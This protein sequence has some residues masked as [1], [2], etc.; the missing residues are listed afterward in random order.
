MK[1]INLCLDVL[2]K[3]TLNN[4][5]AFKIEA[6]LADLKICDLTDLS[7]IITPY[8]VPVFV[9]TKSV[10]PAQ[11]FVAK[12]P[13]IIPIF[14]YYGVNILIEFLLYYQFA[15]ITILYD[16]EDYSL[17]FKDA[18]TK[19]IKDYLYPQLCISATCLVD[20]NCNAENILHQVNEDQYSNFALI[21]LHL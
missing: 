10:T 20:T 17:S 14:Y 1:P 11:D 12:Y 21:R 9:F 18:V 15:I 13:N 7:S 4:K 19:Q 8:S 2:L 3:K 5:M 16:S 6:V